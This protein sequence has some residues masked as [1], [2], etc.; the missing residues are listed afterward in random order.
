[1]VSEKIAALRQKVERR[2]KQRRAKERAKERKKRK[3][4]ERVEANEPETIGEE[5]RAAARQTKLL[6]NDLGA[7]KLSSA[8]KQQAERVSEQAEVSGGQS[9]DVPLTEPAEEFATSAG[10][11]FDTIDGVDRDGD[12]QIDPA[13]LQFGKDFDGDGD[14]SDGELFDTFGQRQSS[15]SQES[16][17]ERKQ[18]EDRFDALFGPVGGRDEEDG[19]AFEPFF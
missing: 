14:L 11:L 9:G 4:R 6:L 18:R 5:A 16:R 8:V 7:Q 2:K 1:M 13:E 3:S 15:T 12:G 17:Q 10:G 19:D